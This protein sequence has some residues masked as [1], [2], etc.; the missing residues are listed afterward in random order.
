MSILCRDQREPTIFI[1][2]SNYQKVF[3]R[4]IAKYA[5]LSVAH[6]LLVYPVYRRTETTAIK[7]SCM[8][9]LVREGVAGPPPGFPYSYVVPSLAL[10]QSLDLQLSL[11]WSDLVSAADKAKNVSLN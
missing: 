7:T 2:K 1:H 6:L 4:Q 9:Y 5:S 3:A 11:V 8:H 10:R